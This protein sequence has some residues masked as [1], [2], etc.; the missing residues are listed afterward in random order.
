MELKVTE[1]K[2]IKLLQPENHF[3]SALHLTLPTIQKPEKW[4]HFI[5]PK[6]R[7]LELGPIYSSPEHTLMFTTP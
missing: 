5:Q 3:P 7:R 6:E 2:R 1:K 4:G